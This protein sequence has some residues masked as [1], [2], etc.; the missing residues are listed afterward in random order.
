MVLRR[1]LQ[2]QR[3]RPRR[4]RRAARRRGRGGRR[5]RRRRPPRPA[6]PSA[7]PTALPRAP[8]RG[9]PRARR[10]PRPWGATAASASLRSKHTRGT[11]NTH[12]THT[13]KY[14][15][16][17]TPCETHSSRKSNTCGWE[18]NLSQRFMPCARCTAWAAVHAL[19]ACLVC[20]ELFRFD[21]IGAF[22]THLQFSAALIAFFCLLLLLPPLLRVL[23]RAALLNLP[24]QGAAAGGAGCERERQGDELPRRGRARPRRRA[25]SEGQRQAPPLGCGGRGG[26]GG[27]EGPQVNGGKTHLRIP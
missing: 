6:S 18:G 27:Q 23:Y 4:R 20:N 17:R 26:H 13:R 22:S 24:G 16:A 21:F 2:T 12:A 1:R 8:P 25:E 14:A 7:R 10:K 19:C 11:R 15:R 9:P 5:R 3:Q